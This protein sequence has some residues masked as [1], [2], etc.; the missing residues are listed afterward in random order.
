MYSWVPDWSDERLLPNPL[1]GYPNNSGAY[2]RRVFHATGDSRSELCTLSTIEPLPLRGYE[3]DRISVLGKPLE[4][5]TSWTDPIRVEKL[6]SSAVQALNPEGLIRSILQQCTR[7]M[8]LWDTAIEWR[9]IALSGD[10]RYPTGEDT[11]TVFWKTLQATVY[12]DSEEDTHARHD[13]FFRDVD[14]R[15]NRCLKVLGLANFDNPWTAAKAMIDSLNE[16]ASGSETETVWK[17][18]L[19]ADVVLERAVMR[20]LARTTKGYLALLPFDAEVTN[21][22]VLLQGGKT[23]YVV[24]RKG[25]SWEFVGDCYVHGIMDGEAWDESRL[26]DILLV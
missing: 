20:R 17:Q 16:T 5:D 2:T 15:R 24:R 9:D 1:N 14:V 7:T 13:G 6:V 8:N 10:A 3:F 11:D 22:I 23:P 12:I 25:G 19:C 26:E 21:S 18:F 4:P